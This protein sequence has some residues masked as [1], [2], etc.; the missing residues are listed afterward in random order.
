MSEFGGGEVDEKEIPE[1]VVNSRGCVDSGLILL[2]D[3]A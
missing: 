1:P 2:V 3:T